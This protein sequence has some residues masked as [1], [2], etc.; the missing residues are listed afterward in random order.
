MQESHGFAVNHLAQAD[1]EILIGD[2]NY[3]PGIEACKQNTCYV[4]F[5]EE[6]TDRY[7]MAHDECCW[8]AWIDLDQCRESGDNAYCLLDGKSQAPYCNCDFS[9]WGKN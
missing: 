9:E 1:W 2:D 7:Q 8:D 4:Y 6:A 5:F 3:F